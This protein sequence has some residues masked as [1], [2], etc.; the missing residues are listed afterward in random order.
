MVIHYNYPF[1]WLFLGE[2]L[3]INPPFSQQNEAGMS[4]TIV[5]HKIFAWQT[6]NQRFSIIHGSFKSFPQS[7][8]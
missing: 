8:K 3:W 1:G 2:K 6:E 7:S 4:P 5:I